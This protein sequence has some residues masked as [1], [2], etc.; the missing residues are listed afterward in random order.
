MPRPKA[1]IPLHSF[2]VYPKLTFFGLDRNQA[3]CFTLPKDTTKTYKSF[4]NLNSSTLQSK[5]IFMIDGEPYPAMIRLVRMNRTK[6]VK[7]EKRK[8]T[9]REVIQFDWKKHKITIF[10]IQA[11]LLEAYYSLKNNGENTEHKVYFYNL[12]DNIFMLNNQDNFEIKEEIRSY[13]A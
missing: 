3:H 8:F 12:E 11:F 5:I 9:K 7:H 1:W 2:F 6:T 4:F 10:A 13:T